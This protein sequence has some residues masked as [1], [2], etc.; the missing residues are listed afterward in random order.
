MH[1]TVRQKRVSFW[2]HEVGGG[3]GFLLPRCS[4]NCLATRGSKQKA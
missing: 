1:S 2:V 3:G 4:C